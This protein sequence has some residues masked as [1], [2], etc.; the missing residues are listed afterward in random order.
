METYVSIYPTGFY[1]DLQMRVLCKETRNLKAFVRWF[2][3][4]WRRR[5]YWN[6]YLCEPY[7]MPQGMK[8]C[9]SGLTPGRAYR[10]YMRRY[11]DL[12]RKAAA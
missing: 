3:E 7:Q 12:R 2:R 11:T 5:S 9:G 8:R 1:R 4:S 10:D 6:G